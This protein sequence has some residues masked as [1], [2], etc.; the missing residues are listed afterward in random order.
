MSKG[1]SIGRLRTGPRLSLGSW[2]V[3]SRLT[4]EEGADLVRAA[5]ERN[6]NRFDIGDYWDHELQNTK[7]FREIVDL[8]GLPRESYELSV[9][10]FTNS[11]RSREDI[12]REQLDLLGVDQIDYVICSRPST[13]E[14]LEAAVEAMAALVETGLSKALAVGLWDGSLLTKAYELMRRAGLATPAFAQYQ[15]N[16]CRREVI[17]SEEYRRLFSTTDIKFQAAF[18]LEGGILA[19][20]V[21]RRRYGPEDRARGE[22]FKD[23]NIARD[24][25]GIRPQMSP[26]VA[27]LAA[28]AKSLGVAPAQLAMAFAATH[29]AIDTVLFGATKIWQL[30]EAV[31]A[32]ELARTRADEVHALVADL[33][34]SGAKAPGLFDASAGLH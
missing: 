8:L 6:I 33:R 12:L 25:G 15:Y 1:D 17:E 5:I 3:F 24:A 9:K 34:L 18:T 30:D 14:T 20:H 13:N 16:V 32:M 26:M 19:G 31:E 4:L 7:R 21:E 10:L 22:W 28:A 23:R 29:P 2:H 27:R 11:A